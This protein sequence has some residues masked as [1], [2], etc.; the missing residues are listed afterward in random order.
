MILMAIGYNMAII[1]II[2]FFFFNRFVIIENLAFCRQNDVIM[3]EPRSPHTVKKNS[4]F[5]REK[6]TE[7][8]FKVL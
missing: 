1:I 8:F 6:N 7:P 2:I 3:Q 4:R 5:Y